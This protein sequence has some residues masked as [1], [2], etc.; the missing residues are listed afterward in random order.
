MKKFLLPACIGTMIMLSACGGNPPEAETTVTPEPLTTT[1]TL[2]ADSS[3]NTI[4]ATT[5]T[6]TT[7]TPGVTQGTTVPVKPNVSTSTAG[8]NPAHGQPGHRCDIEVGAPLNSAPAPTNAQPIQ[9]SPAPTTAKPAT[10]NGSVKL[11]PAH[12]Q[13]GHDCAVAVGAPL[14]G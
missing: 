8:L 4:G 13:P 2:S 5:P 7:A 11:N 3:S 9:A 14:N 12:G 1:P 10:T 6:N